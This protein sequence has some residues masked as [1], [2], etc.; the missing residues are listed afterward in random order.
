MFQDSADTVQKRLQAMLKD[1]KELMGERT[2]EVFA[3]VRRDYRS[4]V[5]GDKASSVEGEMLPRGQRLARR[6]VMKVIDGVERAFKRVAGVLTEDDQETNAE[7]SDEEEEAE[8][9]SSAKEEA[10]DPKSEKISGSEEPSRTLTAQHSPG[11]IS[12]RAAVK[13]EPVDDTT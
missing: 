6:G 8:L 4:I 12:K 3:Q 2:E 11:I 7:L 13:D 10:F 9:A 5:G 1:A